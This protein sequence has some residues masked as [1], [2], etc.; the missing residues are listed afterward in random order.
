MIIAQLSDI[1]AN[2]TREALARLDAVLTWLRPLAP[3]AVIVSGDLAEDGALQSYA[4]VAERLGSLKA[5]V[6]VVPGNMD[7]HGPMR[8]VFGAEHSWGLQGALHSIRDLG[9]L[10]LIGLDV[11]VA[12]QHH[13][14]AAPVLGWLAEQLAEQGPPALLFQ[15]QHPFRCG[16]DNKDRNICLNGAAL[17]DTIA[18]AASPVLG[19]TCGHVHRPLFTSFAGRPA[20]MAPSVARSN[21]LRL[22][23][24]EAQ[25]VDPPGLMIHHFADGRLVSHVVMIAS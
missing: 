21:K 7:H 20:T 18:A 25:R 23:G 3:D 5:P 11:T 12:G 10:R 8:R 4:D 6:Q 13:G 22:D 19:L 17:A 24:K 16:I 15:H 1:H 2:G 14:D 9:S